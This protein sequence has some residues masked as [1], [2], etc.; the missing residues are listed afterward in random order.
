MRGNWRYLA[1]RRPQLQQAFLEAAA[2]T[3]NVSESCRRAGIPRGTLYDWR[4]NDRD[5]GR[6]WDEAVCEAIGLPGDIL[7]RPETRLRGW[8]RLGVRPYRGIAVRAGRYFLLRE[9]FGPR[10]PRLRLGEDPGGHDGGL[11]PGRKRGQRPFHS[12]LKSFV[13]GLLSWRVS[14]GR[15]GKRELTAAFAVK[16]RSLSQSRFE[17]GSNPYIG[18]ARDSAKEKLPPIER[19]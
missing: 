7:L 12:W 11:P 19:L 5:F 18:Q 2:Q 3:G 15:S 8:A 13:S 1:I 14:V 17:T 10:R 4:R 9:G 16:S 6:R